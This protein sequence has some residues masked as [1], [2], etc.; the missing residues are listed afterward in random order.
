MHELK[1]RL[2]SIVSREGLPNQEN[3][4][5]LVS[6]AVKALSSLPEEV[7]PLDASLISGGLVFPP[8]SPRSILVPDLHARPSFLFD[9]LTQFRLEGGNT[10]N[11]C[12]TGDTGDTGD[13]LSALGDNRVRLIFLGDGFHSER[14]R[15]DRWIDAL[16]DYCAGIVCGPAM[17]AEMRDSLSLMELVME[18]LCAFPDRVFFLKGN[19]ENVLNEEGSGNHGFR[20]FADEGNMVRDFLLESWDAELVAEYAAFEKMLPLCA[21]CE[22]FMASH[23][24][25]RDFFAREEIVNARMVPGV[26][27]GLTW[28]GNGESRDGTVQMMLDHYLPGCPGA[29]YFGGHRVVTGGYMLRA[30]GKFIQIH[31]PETRTIAV[32]DSLRDFDPAT[33]IR[34][35]P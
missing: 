16:R 23:A 7:R 14:Q 21:V 6:S 24:E 9:I 33:D 10:G 3:Y 29:V 13:V 22:R 18:L 28:T 25:P 30:G 20:K 19:H 12:D 32:V 34:R 17:T 26:T 35:V 15:I 2:A 27:E 5:S 8:A 1:A 4:R 31:D 11:T